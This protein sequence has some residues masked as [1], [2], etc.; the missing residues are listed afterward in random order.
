LRA[1]SSSQSR[2]SSGSSQK[3]SQ[4]NSC[5][6]PTRLAGAFLRARH[7]GQWKRPNPT[8]VH[9]HVAAIGPTE[10]RKRL[11][12]RRHERPRQG[13][14]FVRV[15]NE[16][17]DA[18]RAL[19]LLCTR[20]ERKARADSRKAMQRFWLVSAPTLASTQNASA[21]LVGRMRPMWV[22]STAEWRDWRGRFD[23]VGSVVGG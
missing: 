22:T 23:P 21:S 6:R 3:R 9:P 11:R 15:W 1:M 18:T 13:I 17:A 4:E 19:A 10:A 16:P 2:S 20:R 5:I 7:V 12:E 8:E 14:V